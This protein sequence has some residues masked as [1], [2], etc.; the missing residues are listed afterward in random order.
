MNLDGS[1][2]NIAAALSTSMDEL[3]VVSDVTGA[4]IDEEGWRNAVI[5]PEPGTADQAMLARTS[6]KG[7][8]SR[9]D[10][11]CFCCGKQGHTGIAER[12]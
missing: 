12:T 11:T 4:L 1:W 3:N 9:T 8:K 7:K 2:S 5:D 10:I 6:G